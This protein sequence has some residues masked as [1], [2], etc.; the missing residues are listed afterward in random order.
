MINNTWGIASLRK[1]SS[2]C[3]LLVIIAFGKTILLINPLGKG[4]NCFDQSELR[5]II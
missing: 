5:K 1:R 4:T 2:L 3:P